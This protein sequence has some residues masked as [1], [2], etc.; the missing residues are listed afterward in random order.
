MTLYDVEINTFDSFQGGQY[1][2]ALL[3]SSLRPILRRW[4]REVRRHVSQGYAL[5]TVF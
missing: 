1:V 2:Q 4:F 5:T 3:V